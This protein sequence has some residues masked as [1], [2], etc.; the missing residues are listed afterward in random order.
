MTKCTLIK[1]SFDQYFFHFYKFIT[2]TPNKE[3]LVYVAFT[4]LSNVHMRQKYIVI[5]DYY[6]YPIDTIFL[7]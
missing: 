2:G 1:V 4:Y 6:Y 3:N 7:T 5:I